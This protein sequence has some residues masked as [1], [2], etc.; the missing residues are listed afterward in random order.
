[1]KIKRITRW[2]MLIAGVL[3]VVGGVGVVSWKIGSTAEKV[4]AYDEA[5]DAEY[6]DM[7]REYP[8]GAQDKSGEDEVLEQINESEALEG[9]GVLESQYDA[10]ARYPGV[11]TKDQHSEGLC[12]LYSSVTT[13]EYNI[14][15]NYE[16]YEVSNKHLDYLTID[17]SYVYKQ[18]G[19]TNVY[20]D[21]YLSVD[22][23][24]YRTDLGTSG[25]NPELIYSMMDPIAIVSESDFTNVMVNNDARLS[26]ITR[27]ED[28]WNNDII[29]E[30][31]RSEILKKNFE[32]QSAYMERQNFSDVNDP[33]KV[34][35]IV[36]G[37]KTASYGFDAART[38]N[39]EAVEAIKNLVN[40][41]GAVKISTF[42]TG[43]RFNNCSDKKIV[44]G[45]NR[46]TFIVD[47]RIERVDP[48]DPES[49]IL[50][51]C[52]ANHG[53]TIVGWDD[54]W[55]YEYNNEERSGAFILQNSWGES[56]EDSMKWYLAYISAVPGMMYFDSVEKYSDYDKYY[57]PE[58]YKT[59]S[60]EPLDSELIFELSAGG[61]EKLEAF[62]I[63]RLNSATNYD[64]YVS[65]TGDRD[66]F[67]KDGTFAPGYGITKYKFNK[68]YDTNGDYAIMLKRSDGGA[69]SA[70]SR[71]RDTLTIMAKEIRVPDGPDSPSNPDLPVRPD[72]PTPEEDLPVPKTAGGVSETAVGKPNTGGNTNTEWM[73]GIVQY[74]LPGVF[75]VGFT[76]V[77]VR[78]KNKGHRKF[79][80]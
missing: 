5:G 9:V 75:V 71:S 64:V 74:L 69:V 19:A 44:D 65:T 53:M 33:S 1:M 35:Y 3:V 47:N 43:D 7:L 11:R 37:A 79:D 13:L 48:N 30:Q 73:A 58:D 66:D 18:A 61:A 59:Q 25:A 76:V 70:A 31:E 36:T 42:G 45:R 38:V 67:V 60:I 55:T 6:E 14:A 80:W 12:W 29:S 68:E 51:E 39:S 28:L 56:P 15:K 26:G 8:E 40:K 50:Y 34:K 10:R 78:K 2:V 52:T 4:S 41:Y 24:F 72:V 27:Y 20:F 17:G 77:F 63:G 49:E 62:T 46:Y 57:G 21:R 23:A 32:N 54:E 22:G 16:N